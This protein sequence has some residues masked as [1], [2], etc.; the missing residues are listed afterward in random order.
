MRSTGGGRTLSQ[1]HDRPNSD[2]EDDAKQGE[3]SA[4]PMIVKTFTSR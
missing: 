3:E 4:Q 2:D 1:Y